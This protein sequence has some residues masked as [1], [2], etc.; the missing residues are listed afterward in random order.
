[1][2]GIFSSVHLPASGLYGALDN[3]P[4]MTLRVITLGVLSFGQAALRVW[5]HGSYSSPASSS[6]L[7][8]EYNL[9]VQT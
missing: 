1:M 3:L 8:V 4:V 9:P 5:H 7:R 2:L 6:Q